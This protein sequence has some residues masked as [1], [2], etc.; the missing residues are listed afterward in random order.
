[1]CVDMNLSTWHSSV[2]SHALVCRGNCSTVGLTKKE[3]ERESGQKEARILCLYLRVIFLAWDIPHA[4]ETNV[5]MFALIVFIFIYVC[6]MECGLVAIKP[7]FT[8]SMEEP[9]RILETS[10]MMVL[11]MLTVAWHLI[12]GSLGHLVTWWCATCHDAIQDVKSYLVL[13]DL[14]HAI[15]LCHC[16]GTLPLV[17]DGGA[18]LDQRPVPAVSLARCKK[19]KSNLF[20]RRDSLRVLASICTCQ[21]CA[22]SLGLKKNNLPWNG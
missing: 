20:P 4:L 13:G 8:M 15:T 18:V 17:L 19:A 21:D 2:K 22:F 5:H 7:C 9:R 12:A 16:H 10:R 14:C 1:M 6:G 3:E 11:Q